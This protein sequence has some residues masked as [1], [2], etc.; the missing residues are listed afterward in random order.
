MRMDSSNRNVSVTQPCSRSQHD[1][2]GLEP[3]KQCAWTCSEKPPLET[4]TRRCRVD[5]RSGEPAVR[6][7]RGTVASPS[8]RACDA[9]MRMDSSN[10]NVSVTQPCSRSQHDPFGLEPDKQCAWTC[11]EKPP[12]ETCTRRCRVD[13]RPCEPAVRPSR[14]TVASSSSRACDAMRMGDLGVFER[15]RSS[16]SRAQ[17]CRSSP[18]LGN[19]QC[20]WT[21]ASRST[22]LEPALRPS[23]GTVAS[24]A[25]ACATAVS[26]R[27]YDRVRSPPQS[28]GSIT[29]RPRSGRALF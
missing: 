20:A 3:D 15:G 24:P 8:S 28:Y 29:E 13:D 25:R 26:S 1:P 9:I 17:V 6:P 23:R 4:C 5:D 10:R 2:F 16:P 22:Q 27:P 21:R 14:G 11:S 12:L 7:S 18:S 19:E